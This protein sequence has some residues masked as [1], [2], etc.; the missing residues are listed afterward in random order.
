MNDYGA[1]MNSP[2]YHRSYLRGAG[3][4]LPSQKDRDDWHRR[5][6]ERNR[7]YNRVVEAAE[8]A[9]EK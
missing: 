1:L 6:Y 9:K 7:R 5:E 2:R 8:K 3:I 4:P